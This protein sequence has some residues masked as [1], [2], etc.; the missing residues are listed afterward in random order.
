MKKEYIISICRVLL[1]ILWMYGAGIKLTNYDTFLFSLSRQPLPHWS[2][3]IIAVAVPALEIGAV[4]LLCIKRVRN[5][6]FLLSLT[7]MTMFTLYVGLALTG[8]FGEIPCS[9]GGIISQLKWQG[10]LI[11]NLIFTAI[12][13]LGWRLNT[14]MRSKGKSENRGTILNNQM[15]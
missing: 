13:L 3:P 9:C 15:V 2:I 4:L 10:H 5:Y 12:A 1:I 8:A 11:F 6:G 7:L 14:D